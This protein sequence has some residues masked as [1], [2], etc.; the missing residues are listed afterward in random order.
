[1]GK[2]NFHA[3]PNN[4]GSAD[5]KHRVAGNVHLDGEIEIHVP[6]S[7][8]KEQDTENK[9]RSARESKKMLIDGITLLFVVVVA[10]INVIQLRTSIESNRISKE[11]L[12]SVQRAYIQILPITN[13]NKNGS[14]HPTM[15]FSVRWDNVGATPAIN[16]I[17][18]HFA[19]I[20]NENL[21]EAEFL[22]VKESFAYNRPIVVIGKG[23]T[24]S[25]VTSFEQ[26]D[27]LGMYD[28]K[29]LSASSVR[30][31]KQDLVFWAWT[32]YQDVFEGTP[33]RVTEFCGVLQDIS[34]DVEGH[35]PA[36]VN[37]RPCASHNCED[38][39]CADYIDVVN[40]KSP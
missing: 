38:Q 29:Q 39:Y 6:P 19:K 5:Q 18:A 10:V 2:N 21:T 31:M 16:A 36:T 3:N 25:Q 9:N 37:Y 24:S 26:K 40:A 28:I 30:P 27:V 35:S 15:D 33:I 7:V 1:L 12:Q 20:R 34:V 32:R 11:S 23:S 17:S 13:F 8:K 4:H 22:S 14:G